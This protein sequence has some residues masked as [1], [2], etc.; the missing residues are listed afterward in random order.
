MI[1]ILKLY[2]GHAMRLGL[3]IL[4]IEVYNN[5]VICNSILIFIP[6]LTLFFLLLSTLKN[7]IVQHWFVWY[8]LYFH[9][10]SPNANCNIVLS[11]LMCHA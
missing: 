8:Y 1:E 3:N 2:A 9:V 4:R 7:N 11:S 10:K 5:S 6:L